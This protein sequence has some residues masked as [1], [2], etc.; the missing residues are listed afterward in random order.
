MVKI[1]PLIEYWSTQ[2]IIELTDEEF[3]E[4]EGLKFPENVDFLEKRMICDSKDA[5]VAD[6][7][8]IEKI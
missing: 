7:K 4:L 5:V 1:R 3:E 6:Y 2:E 8:I